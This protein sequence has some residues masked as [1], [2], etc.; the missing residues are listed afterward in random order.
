MFF[1]FFFFLFHY[2]HVAAAYIIWYCIVF[3]KLFSRH[4]GLDSEFLSSKFFK[5][6][7]KRKNAACA[8]FFNRFLYQIL[9]WKSL[10]GQCGIENIVFSENIL[11]ANSN[12]VTA[13][14]ESYQRFWYETL[15]VWICQTLHYFTDIRKVW[16]CISKCTYFS[17]VPF[18]FFNVYACFF[19]RL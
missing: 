13:S 6:Q 8:Y 19:Q 7:W 17:K 9:K 10:R 3:F 4:A 12:L 2:I 15:S 16:D 18:F 11:F 5:C 1:P 14:V